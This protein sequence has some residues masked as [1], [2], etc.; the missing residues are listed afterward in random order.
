MYISA[1]FSFNSN[2]GNTSSLVSNN[3]LLLL[4]NSNISYNVIQNGTSIV[5][6]EAK[7][8]KVSEQQLFYLMSRGLTEIQ[9][10]DLIIAGFM[11]PFTKELP[12]EYAIELNQLLSLEMEG[13]LG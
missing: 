5:Q 12:L 9:A 3:S 8:S 7:V 4:N 2:I 1:I 11:E 13:S 10:T 6:H